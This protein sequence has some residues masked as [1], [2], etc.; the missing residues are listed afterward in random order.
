MIESKADSQA[1]P[2]RPQV[3]EAVFPSLIRIVSC[4]AVPA[5]AYTS[6]FSIQP[7]AASPQSFG[8]YL[9]AFCRT[10]AGLFKVQA[11]PGTNATITSRG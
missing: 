4:D 3:M 11:I 10:D 9:T 8:K 6:Q 1:W 7:I 5:S 2:F